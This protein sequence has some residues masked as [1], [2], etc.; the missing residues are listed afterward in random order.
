MTEKKISGVHD[1]HY[2]LMKRKLMNACLVLALV[3]GL[4]SCNKVEEDVLQEVQSC[5]KASN[6]VF[7]EYAPGC[8]PTRPRDEESQTIKDAY[9]YNGNRAIHV[10]NNEIVEIINF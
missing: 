6:A 3:F 5:T 9:L 7:Y 8:T 10:V 2:T 1:E 4:F